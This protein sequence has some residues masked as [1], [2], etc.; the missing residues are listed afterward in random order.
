MFHKVIFIQSFLTYLFHNTP[1]YLV[2][3]KGYICNHHSILTLSM[4]TW[5]EETSL[6]HVSYFLLNFVFKISS[7]L[8]VAYSNVTFL[9]LIFFKQI[10]YVFDIFLWVHIF[11]DVLSFPQ[12]PIANLLSN[13]FSLTKISQAFYTLPFFFRL[14]T[15]MGSFFS[16]KVCFY[17]SFSI[18]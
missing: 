1:T 16:I 18:Q 17:K 11:Q 7:D 8:N 14:K 9:S 13:L 6:S 4:C 10:H 5:Q 2:Y 15:F 12:F 3:M